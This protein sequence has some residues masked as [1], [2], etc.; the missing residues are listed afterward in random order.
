M[1]VNVW[2]AMDAAIP[3]IS[4]QEWMDS[5]TV[6]VVSSPYADKKSREGILESWRKL[7][8]GSWRKTFRSGGK[9]YLTDGTELV[10]RVMPLQDV[11]NTIKGAFGLGIRD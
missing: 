1:L 6:A 11:V 7:I 3:R 8:A 5:Y 2:D 4:A 10:K 9:E